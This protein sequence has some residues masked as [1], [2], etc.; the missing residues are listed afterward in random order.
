MLDPISSLKAPPPRYLLESDSSDEE[1]Q[2]AYPASA[3][4]TQRRA[5]PPAPVVSVSPLPGASASE[6]P[7]KAS[8]AVVAIGQAGAY[9]LRRASSARPLLSVTLDSARA[10][11]V[12]ALDGGSALLALNELDSGDAAYAVVEAVL[13]VVAA[14]SWTLVSS[15][16][17]AMYIPSAGEPRALDPPVRYL[18]SS[19]AVSLS[20]PALRTYD[21]PNYVTGVAGAFLSA[22]AHP[23][24]PFHGKAATLLL[25]PLPLSTLAPSAVSSA[26]AAAAPVAAKALGRSAHWTEVDDEPF[27]GLGMGARRP[28]QEAPAGDDLSGMYM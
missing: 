17:P 3:A 4:P 19:S 22:S 18:S 24:S 13:G 15:Y 25:L 28:H 11:T 9:L 1:G 20:S 12:F 16:V 10:G 23:A 21:A 27:V 2:G 8:S 26:L 5:A 14:E 7:L 6:L